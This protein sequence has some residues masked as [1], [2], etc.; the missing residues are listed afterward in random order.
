M[1][2]NAPCGKVYDWPWERA[3]LRPNM[4]KLTNYI[5]ESRQEM[6]KVVWP[7]K[8]ETINYT[9][10]VVIISLGLALFFAVVDFGLNIGLEKIISR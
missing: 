7:S 6:K 8:K 3:F 1:T 10:A 2:Q 9:L 5:K 4:F